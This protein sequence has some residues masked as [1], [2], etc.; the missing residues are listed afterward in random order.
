MVSGTAVGLSMDALA[1]SVANGC[2][3]PKLHL[4]YALRMA[5]S[6]ALFQALMPVIGWSGGLA[7]RGLIQGF[8]HWVAF[9]LLLGIGGKMIWE[10]RPAS[11][12]NG[13]A[14]DCLHL[15]TLLLMS[16]ATSIDAL[17]VGVSFA[18]LDAT[19][20]IPAAVIGL[21]TLINCLI[22][23]RVGCRMG[24]AFES[25]L[26]LAGGLILILI[27]VKIVVEHT[28]KAI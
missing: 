6:F 11:Q 20:W 18:V 16:V 15:P 24:R 9:G 2:L 4:K 21:V 7:F 26:G 5:A 17:A 13:E 28:V 10:S 3:Y 1:V 22:G 8:D 27:G 12:T 19:I 14:R 23:A 25:R